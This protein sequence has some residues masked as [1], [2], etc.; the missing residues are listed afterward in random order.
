MIY[1]ELKREE[2]WKFIYYLK[3]HAV[4]VRKIHFSVGKVAK[5]R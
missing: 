3:L 1:F 5:N 2:R 4:A